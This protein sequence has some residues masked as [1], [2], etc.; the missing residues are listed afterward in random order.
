MRNMIIWTKM[1]VN[2]NPIRG[3]NKKMLT[4]DNVI[5]IEIKKII[6]KKN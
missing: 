4:E 5:I 3:K 1:R 6:D 2:K